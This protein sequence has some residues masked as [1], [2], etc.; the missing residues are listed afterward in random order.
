[1]RPLVTSL[2]LTSLLLLGTAASAQG[3]LFTATNAAQGN[4]IAIFDRAADG[5]VTLNKFLPTGGTGTDGSLGNQGGIIL[6]EDEDYL[7]VVN[8]G[9]H[10]ISVFR[11]FENELLLVD[12]EPARGLMPVGLT[13]HD[14]FVFAVNAGTDSIT[15]FKLEAGGDL[16]FLPGT[17]ARLSGQGTAPAQIEFGPRGRFLYVTEKATN[18]ICRFGLDADRRLVDRVVTPSVGQTP[19]GFEFGLRGQMF[20]SEASGGAAGASTVTSYQQ[21]SSGDLNPI[22]SAV[23][24]TQSAACW[25]AMTPDFRYLYTSNTGNDSISLFRVDFDG[26]ITLVDPQTANTGAGPLDM[27]I[28]RD[29]R[30]LYVLDAAGG[31]IGDYTI[32]AGGALAGIPGSQVVLPT[33]ANGLAVR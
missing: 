18:Q 14:G 6:T 28:T 7:L 1:M 25:I 10:D 11:I 15:G 27:A 26:E 9:S 21:A 5:A 20:V 3:Q 16:V 33:S 23:A 17:R 12:I 13:E 29:S 22:D 30:F 8:A 32:G 19:F 2:R 4:D 24:T 31:L